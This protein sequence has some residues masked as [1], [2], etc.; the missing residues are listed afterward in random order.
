MEY[1]Q[2]VIGHRDG[3]L[4]ISAVGILD[5]KTSPPIFAQ[6]LKYTHEAPQIVIFDL[7]AI[8]G[9]KTAFLNG[10]IEVHNYLIKNGGDL[11]VVKWVIE[12]ILTITGI[13]KKV[14]TF[15]TLENALFYCHEHFPHV[16]DFILNQK[17]QILIKEVS[18]KTDAGDDKNFFTDESKNIPDIEKILSY[19]FIINAS[20][21]HLQAGKYISYR[22]E[23]ILVQMSEHPVL[24]ENHLNIIKDALLKNHPK[25]KNDLESEHDIDFGYVSEKNNISFRVNGF[26][27]LGKLGFSFR[28]IEKKAR[29]CEELGLPKSIEK[30]IRA[31]QGLVL[32]TGPTGSGKSTTLV[33]MLEE[34]NTIRWENIITIEDPVEFIFTDKKSIFSQRE[35]GRDTD[36]FPAA[37]RAA[38]R[39]DPDIVMVGEMRDAATVEA[40]LN[41][42]ET[43]HLVL[44]TLHTSG[45]VQTISRVV[46]FFNAEQQRQIYGRLADSLLGVLSQ[47]L[48]MRRDGTRKRIA[49]F[50]LMLVNPGIKNLIRSGDMAQMNNAI[51]NGRSEGM[52]PMHIHAAELEKRGIIHREDYEGFFTNQDI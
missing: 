30:F 32:I 52:V 8:T 20:D 17:N 41:L 49:I 26:W 46:Q 23:W 34:I 35:I 51:E 37:I 12:D 22:V 43:G 44:S 9:V 14:Q 33:S 39:E 25:M 42:A 7:S 16:I 1:T 27:A 40:A 18:D 4:V 45:S 24:T 5:E 29:T 3:V 50:E 31:K 48:L 28:R 38:M 19:S 21:L 47:R 11:V 13:S 6:I 2:T 15:D 36:S 10:I